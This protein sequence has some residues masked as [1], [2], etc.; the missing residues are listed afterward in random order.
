MT[1]PGVADERRYDVLVSYAR[2]N[3]AL[4]EKFVY[5]PLC[6][7]LV[8]TGGRA[9]IFFDQGPDGVRPGEAFRRA[10]ADAIKRSEA[11]VPVFSRAYFAS[12]MCQWELDIAQEVGQLRAE[13]GERFKLVP[14][15][16]EKGVEVPLHIGAIHYQFFLAEGWFEK[17]CQAIDL[18]PQGAAPGLAFRHPPVEAFVNR[19]LPPVEVVLV[20]DDPRLLHGQE[21]VTIS[22]EHG[23]L[24]GTVIRRTDHGVAVF[25]DLSIGA[26]VPST[27]LIAGYAGGSVQAR[28]D[29]FPVLQE[30]P[31]YLPDDSL[32]EGT[33]AG[34]HHGEAWF[35]GCGAVA[36]LL[37][38]RL[39][40]LDTTGG[41]VSGWDVDGE[42]RLVRCSQSSVVLATWEGRVHVATA[43]GRFS[44]WDLGSYPDRLTIPGDVATTDEHS[45]Y[46]GLW[47]GS[48]YRMGGGGDWPPDLV[49][50]HPEG[51]Q[52]LEAVGERLYVCGLDGRLCVYERGRSLASYQLEPIV[53]LVKAFEQ[54]LVVVGTTKLFQ[55]P[56]D[57]A[58]LLEDPLPL[59]DVVGVFGDTDL[60]VV[61]DAEG[62]GIRFDETLTIRRGFRAAPGVLPCG[63]DRVG[64]C[65]VLANLDG[66]RS[67]VVDGR[68]VR[69]HADGALAVSPEGD[70][71]AVGDERGLRI[72]PRHELGR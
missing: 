37:P 4:V 40:M 20:A 12:D 18:I 49:L 16:L 47:S 68:V 60:P 32:V 29:P 41:H 36:T 63:A 56:F 23:P 26:P 2:E 15:L 7:C 59:G 27:R 46:V 67:L 10:L 33:V 25:D 43:D 1:P 45:V 57:Q 58:H 69:T 55:L 54:A 52:A 51:V 70:R 44:T 14:L 19:T 30:P 21:E 8:P 35:L 48:V 38:G 71:V 24:A 34:L 39:E 50:E 72:V 66:S 11:F 61:V 17:L 6:R 62:R 22:A 13:R 53:R 64:R 5:E 31:L 3:D 42:P 28:T 65:C 9:R